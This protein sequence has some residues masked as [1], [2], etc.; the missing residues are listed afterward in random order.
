[1]TSASAWASVIADAGVTR[2]IDEGNERVQRAGRVHRRARET[3]VE[4]VICARWRLK[5]DACLNYGLVGELAQLGH[6]SLHSSSLDVLFRRLGV[7]QRARVTSANPA[8]QWE[9]LAVHVAWEDLA[10][11]RALSGGGGQAREWVKF[12]FRIRI[13]L[14]V[15]DRDHR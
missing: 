14:G 2:G 8:I 3:Q 4:D 7:G 15:G 12:P 5:R 10:S 9:Q 13:R 6:A 11:I 1:M